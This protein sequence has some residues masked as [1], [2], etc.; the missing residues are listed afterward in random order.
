MI[1]KVEA[2]TKDPLKAAHD[3]EEKML[4][5]ELAEKREYEEK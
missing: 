1:R 3:D 5:E 2:I 4:L